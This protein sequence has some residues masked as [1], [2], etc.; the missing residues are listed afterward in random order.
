MISDQRNNF[1]E[2]IGEVFKSWDWAQDDVVER[3]DKHTA[4]EIIMLLNG[5]FPNQ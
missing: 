5:Q 3:F 2:L 1:R 4:Q